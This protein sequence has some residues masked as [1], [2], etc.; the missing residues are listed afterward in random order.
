MK[1]KCP[2]F[3][4]GHRYIRKGKTMK[5]KCGHTLTVVNG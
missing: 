2:M 4:D 5:C 1:R 3:P